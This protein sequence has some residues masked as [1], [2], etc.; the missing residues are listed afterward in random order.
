MALLNEKTRHQVKDMLKG[1]KDQVKLVVFTQEIECLTCR[2]NRQL[3]E[4]IAALSDRVSVEVFDFVPDK[5][6]AE[7][8]KVDKI[9]AIVVEGAKDYGI[10]FYGI[11]GGYEFTSLIHTIQMV[12]SGESGLSPETK[13]QLKT[14]HYPVHIQVFVTL[15]CP[16]CPGAVQM[17]HKMAI[18][19]DLIRTDMVEASGFPHLINKYKVFSVPKVVIN[20]TIEFERALP[21]SRFLEFIMQAN[22]GMK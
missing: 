7:H 3:L 10:R 1:L 20:E 13:E 14:L 8:Y 9:P 22:G 15:T 19:S 4:E 12:S 18:E 21:E 11:P 17:A 16:Y 2:E 5:D 6:K